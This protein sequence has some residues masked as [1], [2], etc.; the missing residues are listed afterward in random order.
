MPKVSI[1]IPTYN[2]PHY[3]EE[4]LRSIMKQTYQDF[5]VIV[6][7]DGTPSDVNESICSKFDK[8]SY[9]K[10]KNS[11][12]PAKPRN[13][14]IQKA[15]GKYIA[16]VDDDDLWLLEKLEK[17]VAILDSNPSFGLV[18]YYCNVIDEK[19]NLKNKIVGRPGNPSVKH[20]N[21]SMKMMGNWTVM[22]STSF[23]RKEIVDKVGFFNENMP[24][25]GEDAE[26][27]IRCSFFTKFYYIDEAL[28]YY[29]IH[30]N[31]I[32]S[33]EGYENLSIYLKNILVDL[34]FKKTINI[35]QYKALLNNLCGMQIKLF[36][37]YKYI[38][39]HNLFV[40]DKFW[41]FRWNNL[42]LLVFILIKR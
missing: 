24:A 7:D 3:L 37:K 14:G 9:F 5:E 18:H 33:E 42:K 36:K 22:M 2:R 29:R 28:V 21:V 40:L 6:V 13:I 41:I 8:V 19:G 31:N 25:A 38:S 1:I 11:G 30:E 32:S 12:G 17:Q 35:I 20:G 10:I 39:L 23:I 16:F 34:K 4:T 15:K 26:F 27:W